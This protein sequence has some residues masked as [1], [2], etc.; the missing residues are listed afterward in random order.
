MDKESFRQ[1]GYRF[2]D[3]VADYMTGAQ[4]YPVMSQVKPG[5]IKRQL[6]SEPPAREKAT[7]FEANEKGLKKPLAVYVSEEAHSSIEKGVKIAGYGR[8]NKESM[9][10]KGLLDRGKVACFDRHEHGVAEGISEEPRCGN[11]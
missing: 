3:W 11:F 1:A 5:D 8:E 6:P 4:Q 7:A 2:V 9:G 10:R